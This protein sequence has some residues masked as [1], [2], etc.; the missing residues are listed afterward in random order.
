MNID[1]RTIN[2]FSVIDTC[3]IQNI[4]SSSILNSAVINNGFS[5]CV[6]KFV[7]YEMLHKQSSAPSD[8]ENEIK[9]I[10]RQEVAKGKFECHNLSI[11]DLQEIEILESRKKLGKGEL[12]IIAFAKKINQGIMT[13]DQQARKLGESVLGKDR[14]QTTPQLLGWFFYNRILIDSELDVICYEH[15]S[16]KRPLEKFFREVY[17]ESL[18]IK[19]MCGNNS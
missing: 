8:A 4:L 17:H 15:T 1:I 14:I 5:F 3:S 11:E 2:K 16:K 10:Y 12:S 9:I 18:R 13:D 19:L 6:T 7:E